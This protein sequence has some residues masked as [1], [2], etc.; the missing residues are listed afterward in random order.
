MATGL[1]A[2]TVSDNRAHFTAIQR[3]VSHSNKLKTSK[4]NTI[5]VV[6]LPLVLPNWDTSAVVL[7]NRCV[8]RG[9]RPISLDP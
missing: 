3:T 9:L 8:A 2:L 1:L 7:Q 5:L 6:K 4:L